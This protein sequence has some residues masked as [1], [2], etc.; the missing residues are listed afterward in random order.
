[1]PIRS[2]PGALALSPFR[3]EALNWRL[4][5]LGARLTA[6]SEVFVVF[7]ADP[8]IS[9][10]R[11]AEVLQWG[12]LAAD[13]CA[14]NS[15]WV[16]PRV[17][18]RSPWSSKATDILQ[19]CGLSV[20]R[21][22]R[23]LRYAFSEWP[24]HPQAV[25]QVEA[26]LH[27]PM[28][29]S[30]LRDPAQFAQMHQ[31]P[32]AG[33]LLHIDSDVAALTKANAQLG[34]ALSDDEIDYLAKRYAQ[35]ERAATDAE[36]MMFAQA[37]S[38][39]CRHKVFNASWTLDGE[40]Q[41]SSLFGHIKNTHVITPQGT[42]VAYKDNAAVLAG[43]VGARFL[44]DA[45]GQY[46]AHIEPIHLAIKV[47]THNH[48]TAIAPYAGAAT[49]AGGE[50]RD[51]GATGR[52]ARPKA[53]LTGFSVSHLRFADAPQPWES[54]RSLPQ[55]LA[56]ARRIMLEGPIGAA[57]FNNE[58]G[59]P[60]LAGYFRTFEHFD[61]DACKG[62]AF[63]K[64][65]MIAGGLGSVRAG[66]V[67]KG[68]LQAGDAVIVLG[69]P[70]MLIGLG[71][72]A[73]S[74]QASGV[75][76][77]SRDFASV[78]RDNAEMER[79]CQE[80]IDRC[81][82]LGADNP[83]VSI[84]DVGAGGLSNAIP[85][86]LHDSGVGGDLNLGAVLNDDP[87]M[88]PMQIWCNEAQ[89]RYVLGVRPP[90]LPRFV[91]L[92]ERERCLY[93]IVG[94]AT[95]AQHLRVVL[96]ATAVI[97]L[98]MD[99]LFGNA[100]KMHR[101]AHRHQ[102]QPGAALDLRAMDVATALLSV[103][104][105]PSVGS[106]QFLITIGDRSVGGLSHR[107]QM[108]GPWQT[109]VADVAVTLADFDGYTGEAMCIAERTPIAVLDARAAARMAVGEALTNVY[110][111]PIEHIEDIK[112]SANWM[113]A[114]G[115]PDMDGALY[116]AVETIGRDLCPALGLGIPVGK[117][118]LSM[119]AQWR[120]ETG[121]ECRTRAPVSLI[122][123][124]FAPLA[125][126]RQT[127]TPELQ[128]RDG[129]SAIWLVN[130]GAASA[131]LGGSA[132]AQV[133]GLLGDVP[134]DLD[135]PLVF[136]QALV[137]LAAQKR[138]GR[139]LAWHDRSDG[140]LIVS[141]L[142]MAFAA[143]LGV[144]IELPENACALTELCNEELGVLIEVANADIDA[145]L[146]S[147]RAAGLSALLR[148]V[149]AAHAD[150][151]LRVQSAGA[152]LIDIDMATLISAWGETSW[153]LQRERDDPDSVD[154]EFARLADYNAP[155]LVEAPSF[156]VQD[157]I[158]AP[159]IATGA[160]PRVA[161]LREQGVN[162]QLEMAAAFDRAGFSAIDVHI[163]DL[164]SGRRK[165]SEFK[166]LAACGGFSY[167]DVLG[168]G[169]GWAKGI[170]H[171]AKLSEQF[172]AFFADQSTFTLG[173]CNGCQMM[174][175]LRDLVPGAQ[176]WPRFL[177]NRSEQYE[178]RLVQVEV[179]DSP[180]VLLAGMTGS[181]LPLVVSHGE[182]RADWGGAAMPAS[183]APALRFIESDGRVAQAYPANPNGSPDGYTGFTTTDGRALILMPHPERVFRRV[184]MSWAAP[185]AEAS[186]WLRVFRN[187][188]V[189]VG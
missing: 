59:R 49:G 99:V 91:A 152:T 22:E 129:S 146:A 55:H 95:A 50:I 186:P 7:G 90:D 19:R 185:G 107:D 145:L 6:V 72:G 77:A 48:P 187:A 123:S 136:R 24:D 171:H 180:S 176:G 122:I 28:T 156:A 27:D 65:I 75:G 106:K 31:H 17:G 4:R 165:L 115:D 166:G 79:R 160:R 52:G 36:L 89:E 177:R 68:F 153:R 143:R 164:Q 119:R 15:I 163:S 42:L 159:Y 116:A 178:A 44:A 109:P 14:A 182:G 155:G 108:V 74:S 188:R 37:N 81:I 189:F 117:D 70:A 16:A 181:R 111:A 92:A 183:A 32:V 179:L 5:A 61:G 131:R 169:Q 130:L 141:A 128:R 88:S 41:P 2:F 148:R 103:L 51:E 18:T 140:G 66:D 73:A 139:I 94:H 54:A 83:M 157:D 56:S 147:A 172:R 38:E 124:A 29:Q 47:E 173:V 30:V 168:A 87:G 53:G 142:E 64:P 33:E 158:A 85:E 144:Q 121:A 13:I 101:Q 20:A 114:V 10:A 161:I 82:A 80:V 86:L 113:A 96:D 127:L 1:M 149:G 126:V 174:S 43:R 184:Q 23:L 71:G 12:E 60:A 105:F 39:H 162:G 57:A 170:R 110:A 112:L 137:W 40:T 154:Q 11:L 3:V 21:V 118:S 125:D 132:L 58:F 97:D 135:D 134:P 76:S 8:S 78:Q 35:L 175:G 9:D 63:D 45:D 93:A 120:S 167:G 150:G 34:L 98:P 62:Y 67:A 138:A 69:G 84:H 151:R 100:P 46:R 104:R 133:Q 25:G 26:L 102:P